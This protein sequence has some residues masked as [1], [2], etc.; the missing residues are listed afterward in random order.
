MYIR[1]VY[2]IILKPLFFLFTPEKAH[3]LALALFRLALWIPGYGFF[4]DL[5]YRKRTQQRPVEV[6]G[7]NFKNPIGLA[8]GFDKNAAYIHLM[9][10]LGFSHIEVGTVTPLAQAGNPK[11]RL[12]RLPKDEAL[13]NRMGFNN[14]GVD[15]M[16]RNL[17][18]S[19][20]QKARAKYGVLIG[21]N[22]GKN[23]VTE[24]AD[25]WKDYCTC[26]SKLAPYVDYFVINVSSPN[27]PGL[28]ELQEKGPL[29]EIIQKI[30]ALNKA[31]PAPKPV[32]LK[33]APDLNDAQLQDIVEIAKSGSL[34]G[35]IAGN[36][37]ISRNGLRTDQTK[38]EKIGGGGLS[39]APLKRRSNEV[40]WYLRRALGNEMPLIGVGGIQNARDMQE[41]LDRGAQLVQV[42]T[43]LIYA[44][45]DI[46]IRL[47]R[48][49]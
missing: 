21:G 40:L 24:N 49:S 22:I 23:K 33:I 18:S 34:A 47:L 41:K 1:G 7:L 16:V 17:Q 26:F 14:A 38:V 13:I 11:P 43:G 20:V 31:L 6:F 36:T 27:T 42:Y 45:Q 48:R 15:A 29:L 19:K 3:Y 4:H 46:V 5:R 44:G 25:A 37:T 12:F 39:G 28:R 8:A 32:L 30:D 9:A 10:R 35:I 2:K